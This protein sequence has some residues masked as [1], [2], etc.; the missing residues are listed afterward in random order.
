MFFING[1]QVNVGDLL[2][3]PSREIYKVLDIKEV[4]NDGVHLSIKQ[5]STN[6]TFKNLPYPKNWE[7]HGVKFVSPNYKQ[8]AVLS[9]IKYLDERY[10]LNQQKK[11]Q[12]ESISLG[13]GDN[14]LQQGESV[15]YLESARHAWLSTGIDEDTLEYMRQV[16]REYAN[17]RG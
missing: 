16:A 14:N 3:W 6:D 2:Q 13:L 12:H 11:K 9:K 10:K 7:A 4:N 5:I 17:R 1:T 15:R 8:D